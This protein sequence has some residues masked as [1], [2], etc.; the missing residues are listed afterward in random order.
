MLLDDVRAAVSR[1][2][3]SSRTAEAYV[4]WIRMGVVEV[5]E[6][7]THLAVDEEVA[8]STQNQAQSAVL[9]LYREVLALA[10]PGL[11][12]LERAKHVRP[13]P[14]VLSRQEVARILA[15]LDPRVVA[16]GVVAV[17]RGPALGGVPDVAGQGSRSRPRPDPGSSRKGR[18]GS[19]HDASGS[20]TAEA[21]ASPR[22]GAGSA[23]A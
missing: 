4:Y 7:L 18:Q 9:F 2:G 23:R 21:R 5:R 3:Y 16:A 13:L 6:F 12:D 14:V 20:G 22:R 11:D 19:G 8:S 15:R 10:V 17:R 1:L